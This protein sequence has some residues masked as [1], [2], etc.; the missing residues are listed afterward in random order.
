[1]RI[2]SRALKD[3]WF[4]YPVCEYVVCVSVFTCVCMCLCT[5][6]CAFETFFSGFCH[7]CFTHFN[8]CRELDFG[9]TLCV[10]CCVN[11]THTHAHTHTH[12]ER[13]RNKR[14]ETSTHAYAS[15]HTQVRTHFQLQIR[16]SRHFGAKLN[17]SARN[18]TTNIT[19][20]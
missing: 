18:N 5:C 19:I 15:V 4:P 7:R 6:V 13:E 11:H 14:E 9:R 2:E 1:V 17:R 20:R 8:Q 10:G 16:N 12:I 3:R